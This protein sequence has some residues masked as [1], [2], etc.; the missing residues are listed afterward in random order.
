MAPRRASFDSDTDF[1]SDID[2]V[3]VPMNP[4]AA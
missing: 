2:A 4:A 3:G 1:D